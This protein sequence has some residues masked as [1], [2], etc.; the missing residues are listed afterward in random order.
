MEE[1]NNNRVVGRFDPPEETPPLDTETSGKIFAQNCRCVARFFPFHERRTLGGDN[2][3][4]IMDTGE[5]VEDNS[6]VGCSISRDKSS[7]VDQCQLVLKPT[8]NH[9]NLIK[10]GD[11]AIIYLDSVDN[12]DVQALKGVRFVGVVDRT[13]ISTVTANNGTVSTRIMVYLSSWGKGLAMTHTV[14]DP[15]LSVLIGGSETTNILVGFQIKGTPVDFVREYIEVFLG[16]A[17]KALFA[18][19][20]STLQALLIPPKLYKAINKSDW[21]SSPN[22]TKGSMPCLLDIMYVQLMQSAAEGF[23]TF[24]NISRVMTSTLWDILKSAHHEMMNELFTDTRHGVPCL[25]M[26]KKPLS[27]KIRK[28]RIDETVIDIPKRYILNTN[29]GTSDAEVYNYLSI[30]SSDSLFGD[31]AS[32]SAAASPGR[33]PIVLVDSTRRF[34]IKHIQFTTEYAFLSSTQEVSFNQVFQWGSELAEYWF[35]YYHYETGTVD[36]LGAT[37]DIHVGEWIRLEQTGIYLVEGATWSW[38]FGQPIVASLS[39]T[40][41]IGLDGKWL[42][43]N[44]DPDYTI[45]GLT[46]YENPSGIDFSMGQEAEELP[47]DLEGDYGVRAGIVAPAIASPPTGGV[48]R[49]S[50]KA[51]SDTNIYKTD[52]NGPKPIVS[53]TLGEAA[54][55]EVSATL[56]EAPINCNTPGEKSTGTLSDLVNLG[57]DDPVCIGNESLFTTNNKRKWF[58]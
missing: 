1:N 46:L 5:F 9:Y 8:R 55:L 11:W 12:I 2:V 13:A 34:G 10:P 56:G 57:D 15:Y 47:K 42:D 17:Q 24:K 4:H 54:K 52:V 31:S 58:P 37:F 51:K 29:L 16:N 49:R 43:Q 18:N 33:L 3:E 7:P 27:P 19:Y 20:K 28:E 48:G 44:K 25:I 26:R 23:A 14:Q 32:F 45:T 36:V 41:G 50:N 53:A 35:N 22:Y 21:V 39:L 30:L 6:I 38:S 40:H